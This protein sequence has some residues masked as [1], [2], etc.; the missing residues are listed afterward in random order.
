MIIRVMLQSWLSWIAGRQLEA[1]PNRFE[2]KI[3][4]FM[5]SI[6]PWHRARSTSR[7]VVAT[8]LEVMSWNAESDRDVLNQPTPKRSEHA[9]YQACSTALSDREFRISDSSVY[10]EM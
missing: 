5:S 9:Q 4:S 8:G 7:A 2:V 1:V 10:H 3:T 6:S